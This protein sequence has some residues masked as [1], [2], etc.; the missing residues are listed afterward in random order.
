MIKDQL[1][2]L[3]LT[4]NGDAHYKSLFK[5]VGCAYERRLKQTN[6]HHHNDNKPKD[7]MVNKKRLDD[8]G[9]YKENQGKKNF[10]KVSGSKNLRIE[11]K[12]TKPVN[13]DKE[14]ALKDVL[15]SLLEARGKRD[16]CKHCG[17]TEH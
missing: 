5:Q 12:H 15:E 6:K 3:K 11:K 2:F 17:S 8:D 9:D 7:K 13:M 1:S 4:P 10:E 16:K 14:Q